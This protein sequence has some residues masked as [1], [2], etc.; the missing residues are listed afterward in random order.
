MILFLIVFGKVVWEMIL[1]VAAFANAR[2]AEFTLINN[3]C[4]I[5]VVW[6]FIFKSVKEFID[7]NVGMIFVVFF[8]VVLVYVVFLVI[9]YVVTYAF[10]FF[11]F[12]RVACVMMFS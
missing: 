3:S 5:I 6:M 10:G 12:E 4:F 1:V 7:I 11:G 2:K 9:N 8:V